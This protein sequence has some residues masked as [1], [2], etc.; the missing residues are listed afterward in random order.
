[1][2]IVELLKKEYILF[3]NNKKQLAITILLPLFFSLIYLFMFSLSETGFKV[4]ICNLDNGIYSGEFIT[5]M[6]NEVETELLT[7]NNAT[8]CSIQIK[9]SIMKGALIGIIVDPDFSEKI[10]SYRQ[11]VLTIYFDNSKPNLGFFSQTYVNNRINSLS[12]QVLRD[13]EEKIKSAT[14]KI[15]ND[16]DSTIGILELINFS[17]PDIIRNPYDQLY[18]NIQY[19]KGN[20]SNLNRIDLEFLVNPI[21]TQ[22]VGVFEGRN[23]GGF[24]FSVLYTVLNLFVLLLLSSVSMVYDKRN[25]FLTRLKTST[26]P[27]IY[28]IISKIVFFSIIGALIFIPSFL[29]FLFKDAYFSVNYATLIISIITISS[30]S[31][32]LGSIIGLTSNDESSSIMVSLFVGLTFMLISGLFYPVELLPQ[33]ISTSLNAL[34]TS[35]EFKLLNYALVFNSGISSTTAAIVPLIIYLGLFIAVNYLLISKQHD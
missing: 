35:F 6:Q 16:L 13:S 29:V 33:L 8:G 27:I 28:Y 25:N 18:T 5:T 30:I 4:A 12:T 32:L 3:K 9:D 15:E 23:S 21:S 31:T 19:Y 1:M 20:I 17:I 34:P 11:P 26:T 22:L 7:A 2:K 10:E 24:S 14:F